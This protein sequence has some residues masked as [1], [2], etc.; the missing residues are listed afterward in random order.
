M[1]HLTDV[2]NWAIRK[3]ELDAKN[4]LYYSQKDFQNLLVNHSKKLGIPSH[5]LQGVLARA[6]LSWVRCFK[7]T[8]KRPQHDRDVNAARNTLLAGAGTAHE[9]VFHG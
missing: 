9:E 1:W 8:A 2:W 5:V 4:K 7:K 3:I 6:Y